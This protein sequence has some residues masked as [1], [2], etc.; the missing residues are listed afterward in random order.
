MKDKYNFR[1]IDCSE[2][3][4]MENGDVILVN[5]WVDKLIN[6]RLDKKVTINLRIKKNVIDEIIRQR[7]MQF[8][9]I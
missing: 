1:E 8:L 4:S 2:I 9:K 7:I 6:G 5:G 3:S